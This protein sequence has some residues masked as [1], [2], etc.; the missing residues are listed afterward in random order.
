[1]EKLIRKNAV[2]YKEMMRDMKRPK[3]LII[4]MVINL[5]IGVIVAG[6]FTYVAI[7][8]AVFERISNS[9]FIIMFRVIIIT[10]AAF[11][12]F[13]APA[14]TAGAVSL[15]KERQ[16]LDVLLTTRMTPWEIIKGK[17]LSNVVFMS[18]LVLSTMPAMS[19]VFIYGGINILQMFAIV[20]CLLVLI[21]Y[22]SSFGV[23]FSAATK[24]TVASVILTYI[25]MVIFMSLTFSIPFMVT[26]FGLIIEESVYDYVHYTLNNVTWPEHF[27]PYEYLYATMYLNPF[28]TLFDCMGT[29]LGF[30]IDGESFNGMRGIIKEIHDDA[31]IFIG[32]NNILVILWTPISMAVQLLFSFLLLKLSAVCLNPVKGKKAK[33]IK[34]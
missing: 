8:G 27:L 23:F 6:F 30:Q 2:L 13:M 19:F 34:K 15:E 29:V 17:Y 16:T 11:I 7:G 32:P 21:M 14:L 25:V 3:A 20:L 1:M 12:T 26:I 18:L 33:K 10:E 9:T 24:S 22:I 5:L 31:G 28:V 4:M